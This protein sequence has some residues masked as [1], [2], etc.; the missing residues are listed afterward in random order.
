MRAIRLRAAGLK[1]PL[2]IS[3]R[4]ELSWNCEGGRKQTAYQVV[5]MTGDEVVFDSGKVQ[6][7]SMHL[8]Y[9]MPLQSRQR[10]N[11]KVC[12]WDEGDVPGEWTESF[13]KMGLLTDRDWRAKWITG[14]YTVN[15]KERYPVDCF[16]KAFRVKKKLRRARLY[17]TACV[18]QAVAL[19][20]E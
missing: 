10:V 1:E 4:P 13:F 6:S 5:C 11:W 8:T 15:K 12:L 14:D 9:P 18:L 20:G 17:T 16:R 2:G 3:V 19:N 7:D